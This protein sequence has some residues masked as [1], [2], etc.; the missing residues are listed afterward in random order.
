MRHDFDSPATKKK[1]GCRATAAPYM[2][3]E[4]VGGLSLARAPT[5]GVRLARDLRVRHRAHDRTH[6]ELLVRLDRNLLRAAVLLAPDQR[7]LG[8]DLDVRIDD[9]ER[10]H[11]A[12]VVAVAREH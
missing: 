7:H 8:A 5:L 9:A 3:N 10:E 11:R 2:K 4:T 12:L 6:L 1:G